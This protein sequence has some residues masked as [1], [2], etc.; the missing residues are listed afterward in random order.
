MGIVVAA[1]VNFVFLFFKKLPKKK[2]KG[3]GM[4]QFLKNKLVSCSQNG[5]VQEI[6]SVCL[7]ALC[8]HTEQYLTSSC[9]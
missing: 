9:N 4:C 3:D 6:F 1:Q 7:P 2:K 5:F 8:C